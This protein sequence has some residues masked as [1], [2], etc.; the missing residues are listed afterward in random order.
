[1]SHG[2]LFWITDR[3][4]SRERIERGEQWWNNWWKR[5]KGRRW[6]LCGLLVHAS[7]LRHH[8]VQTPQRERRPVVYHG[9]PPL[10]LPISISLALDS[11]IVLPLRPTHPA[12]LLPHLG[13]WTK[14]ERFHPT[15]LNIFIFTFSILF[16]HDHMTWERCFWA[17]P[18]QFS[19]NF[20]HAI[21]SSEI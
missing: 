9:G 18:D 8:G 11:I 12:S 17:C 19:N 16:F 5:G 2:Y 15:P 20:L 4:E 3:L 14:P 21:I 10:F 13:Y 1:M 6:G 7:T